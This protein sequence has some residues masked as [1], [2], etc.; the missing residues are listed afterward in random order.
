[1]WSMAKRR[2]EARVRARWNP[3]LSFDGD[4]K[5]AFAF[6]E[7]C[8][9]GKVVASMTWGESPLAAQVPEL[10][11]KIIHLSFTLGD[12]MLTGADVPH[13]QYE[14]PRGF[15]VLL[16]VETAASAERIFAA[17]ARKGTVQMPLEKTFWAERFGMV[18]DRFRIPWMVNCG[19]DA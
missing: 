1:M 8:L 15:Q 6:Y 4:C 11:K 17:L 14:K 19:N 5:A 3:H 18:T 16:N 7:K 13:E 10:K 12:Q 2:S 9:G